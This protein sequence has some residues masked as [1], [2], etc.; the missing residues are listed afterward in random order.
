MKN[1]VSF[2]T[3]KRLKE[4]GFNQHEFEFGQFWYAP[5]GNLCVMSGDGIYSDEA[6]VMLK[7]GNTMFIKTYDIVFAPTATDIL[8]ELQAIT[9]TDR[10]WALMPLSGD[11]KWEWVLQLWGE[12]KTACIAHFFNA[13]SAE[14]AAEAWLKIYA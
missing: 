12:D 7:N 1:I 11:T 13:N 8:P 6:R 10:L 14:A 2:E 9:K 5:N 4:A 3:A